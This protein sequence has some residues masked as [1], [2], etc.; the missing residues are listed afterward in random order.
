MTPFYN[1]DVTEKELIVF[2]GENR[3]GIFEDFSDIL[4][5]VQKEFP[6]RSVGY[7]DVFVAVGKVDICLVQSGKARDI[8]LQE[9]FNTLEQTLR[10]SLSVIGKLLRN[11][12]SKGL[13]PNELG[14]ELST[15]TAKLTQESIDRTHWYSEFLRVDRQRYELSVSNT[16]IRAVAV[17][18]LLI[19]AILLFTR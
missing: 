4:R 13:E 15:L 6:D 18:S 11:H 2:L 16:L 7:S 17:V 10:D 3:D 9:Q 1:N 19:T 5:A 12:M 8:A 14:S